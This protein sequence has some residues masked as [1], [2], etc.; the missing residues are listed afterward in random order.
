[1]CIRDRYQRRVRGTT[2]LS[3][4]KGRLTDFFVLCKSQN[5]T[6]TLHF[7]FLFND[8]YRNMAK[9]LERFLP[10]DSHPCESMGDLFLQAQAAQTPNPWCKID[11]YKDAFMCLM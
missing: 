4:V 11:P 6:L 8:E 7:W 1:M 3:T 5:V 2:E 10:A 9:H